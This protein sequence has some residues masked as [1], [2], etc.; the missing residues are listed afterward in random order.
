ME[1]QL[2]PKPIPLLELIIEVIWNDLAQFSFYY[3]R[4]RDEKL[5]VRGA[6]P[7]KDDR[8]VSESFWGYPSL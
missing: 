7:G 1:G 4:V 8:G 2:L 6:S 3:Q 5:T